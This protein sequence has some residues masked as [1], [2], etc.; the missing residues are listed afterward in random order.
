MTLGNRHVE[1]PGAIEKMQHL[2]TRGAARNDNV[3]NEEKN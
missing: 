3:L 2:V 1:P